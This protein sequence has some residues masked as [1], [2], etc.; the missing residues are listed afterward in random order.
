MKDDDLAT[1]E[2]TQE[3]DTEATE[4]VST[5]FDYQA[6]QEEKA[7][8]G[9]WKPLEDWEGKPEDW[10]SAEAFNIRGEFIGKMKHQ[11]SK[12]A[13]EIAGLNQFHQVAMKSK[14]DELQQKK[15]EVIREGA[16]TAVEDVKNLD[17]Q[18]SSLQAPTQVA[19]AEDPAL[20]AWKA[21]NSWINTPGAKSTYAYATYNQAA[22]AGWTT[23]QCIAHM[24]QEMAKEYPAKPRN[25]E[26]TAMSE[27]GNGPRGNAPAKT[28]KL[29]MSDVTSEELKLRSQ[30]PASW[31][32]EGKFLK[33]VENS[34][35]L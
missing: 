28:G 14:I 6:H 19:P 22:N 27:K 20:T 8:A 11:D 13:D 35:K 1:E 5:E 26:T 7:A 9:G 31:S 32:D 2:E 21:N 4:D 10:S 15:E 3:T 24:D 12:H 30:G 18:I 34:R 33:A 23:A 29:T 25:K 16:D 17:H